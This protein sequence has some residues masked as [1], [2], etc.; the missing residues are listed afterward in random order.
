MG[1]WQ[2]SLR[3]PGKP[4]TPLVAQVIALGKGRFQANIL[5]A[6]DQPGALI[7][8][9]HGECENVAVHL[10]GQAG[11]GGFAGTKWQ[12]IIRGQNFTGSFRST[13]RGSFRMQKTL[14]LSPTLGAKP[15][16]NALVLFDGTNF[17]HWRSS[18]PDQSAPQPVRWDLIDGAM[19]V[20][21]GSGSI[22]TKR[23][24][25]DFKLHLEF[26]T[27]V[28]PEARGQARGNSGVY[29]QGRYEV[30]ILDS[31]GL[32]GLDNECGGI[33]KVARPRVNMCAPPMQWQTYDITFHAPRFDQTGTKT[34]NARLTV[35]HNGVMI[36]QDLDVPGPTDG[37]LDTN[38][39][40]P[41]GIY[42]QDH[43]NAV[44]FRNIWLVELQ[45]DKDG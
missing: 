22:I 34:R 27:P 19:Q 28:M 30:Q 17:D 8:I 45:A 2:G 16:E 14:R 29:L 37:G 40:E 35:L 11:S 32:E 20:K 7:T 36:H 39:A 21:P 38:I 41:A 31:Y 44:Q 9:L 24:F 4:E 23:K 43:G 1:D 5:A 33:Y 3:S 25:D 42:L 10:V 26:C 6:F 15:P 18:A 12:A 13:F